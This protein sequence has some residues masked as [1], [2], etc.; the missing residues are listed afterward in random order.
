MPDN[1]RYPIKENQKSWKI[2]TF[3]FKSSMIMQIQKSAYSLSIRLSY[4]S[5]L[6]CINNFNLFYFIFCLVCFG[7]DFAQIL[8]RRSSCAHTNSWI[9]ID[10]FCLEFILEN[11]YSYTMYPCNTILWCI[12]DFILVHQNSGFCS[13]FSLF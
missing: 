1:V 13:F 7:L 4:D 11:Y 6:W 8:W 5:I 9:L 2:Y 3:T 10:Y 12:K